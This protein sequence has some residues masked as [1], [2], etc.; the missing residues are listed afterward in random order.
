MGRDPPDRFTKQFDLSTPGQVA[1][2]GLE[3]G[4]LASAVRPDQGDEFARSDLE[5]DPF[6]GLN[7]A[8]G[9]LE[10][11]HL[12]YRLKHGRLLQGWCPD[13]LQSRPGRD[14]H[15]QGALPQF[16]GPGQ[17]RLPGHKVPSPV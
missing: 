2:Q 14:V 6:D 16:V 10:T 13:R 9:H 1:G 8:I 7:S 4:G 17:E 15:L 11:C 12:E 3:R 5:I